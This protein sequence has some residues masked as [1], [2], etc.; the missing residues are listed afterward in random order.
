MNIEH[1]TPDAERSM[2]EVDRGRSTFDVERWMFD[3]LTG[4]V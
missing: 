3:V 4:P 2:F 1:R